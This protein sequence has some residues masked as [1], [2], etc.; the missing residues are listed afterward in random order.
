L[1]RI[2]CRR[3]FALILLCLVIATACAGQAADGPSKRVLIISTGSRLSPG[4][5]VVDQKILQALTTIESVRIDTY[6]EN[7]D[8]VRF[9]TE[10]SQLIFRE[11]LAAR[12]AEQ[13]PD[14]VI[15]VFV[16]TLGV[17]A[18]S[19]TQVLVL[20]ARRVRNLRDC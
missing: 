5:T 18:N 13:P 10:R 7:L 15:L 1:Q 17:A 12:Y 9:P 20:C 11:Y 8:I 6:A 19:L 2:V 14:L 3:G 16:G 4:F